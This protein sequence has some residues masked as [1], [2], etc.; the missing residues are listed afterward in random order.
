MEVVA[1]AMS[2]DSREARV[3]NRLKGIRWAIP[4]L[5]LCLA[6]VLASAQG[7]SRA[8]SRNHPPVISGTPP[9]SVVAG[10][11]YDFLPVA[12]DP[13]GNALTFSIK[14]RPSWATFSSTTGR[15]QGTPRVA[16][17]RVYSNIVISVR[18]WRRSTSLPAFSITVTVP[19]TNIAPTISGTPA[20]SVQQ[21]TQYTFQPTASDANGDPLTFSIVNR[22]VWASF[23]SST[24]RLQGTPTAANVGTTGGIVI[25]VT[26]GIASTSLAAFDITV[27]SAA[28][29]SAVLSWLPPTRNTDGS[30]LTN[31][32]GYR[33][34][35]GTSP[36]SYPNQVT[37]NNPG[38]TTY[39][40][41]NL[42]SGTYYFAVTA[43]NS[44]GAES[45]L[46]NSASKTIP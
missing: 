44:T 28:T 18:D 24:G 26:D 10:Q 7:G 38:L 36:G 46:S 42:V 34:Y 3:G 14:N 30:P 32:A 43:F 23:S 22:P 33:V 41:D 15:L 6:P 12:S 8:S 13:D 21:G 17:A 9:S 19:P 29:G 1:S 16:D 27:Q 5:A 4:A 45:Q 20:T 39:V 40:V 11:P 35:W 2:G 25:T 37:L 31:L